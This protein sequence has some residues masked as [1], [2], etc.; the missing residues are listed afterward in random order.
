MAL[1]LTLPVVQRRGEIEDLLRRFRVLVLTGETGSGKTTQLPQ[2]VWG[3]REDGGATR[4]GSRGELPPP[5]PH[6]LGTSPAGGGGG[7]VHTQ[8]RRLAARAVA[9]RIAEEMG[10]RVGGLVGYKVRFEER[11]SRE[12]GITVMTDGMLLAEIAQDPELSAYSTVILDEAHERSLNVDILLGYLK[13]L[14]ERR[15]DLRVIVTSAT[16]EPRRFSDFFGGPAVA[17]VL[18]VS[19][20]TYGVEVRY[21]T[22]RW[23]EDEDPEVDPQAVVEAVDELT[24]PTVAAGDVLVFLP[25][26]REIR[27]CAEALR[28]A[29]VDAE[30]LPLFSKLSN[31]EQDRIFHWKA[32]GK[33]RVILSTN[34]AETSLTVPGIRHVVDTGL[35]RRNFYDAGRKVQTLPVVRVSRASA[36]Q[37]KGRCGRVAAGVCVRL[38]SEKGYQARPVFTEPEIRRT[39]LASVILQVSAMGLSLERLPLLDPPDA[40]AV[41]EGYE[42]LVELGA[43]TKGTRVGEPGSGYRITEVGRRLSRLPVDPRIG[44]MLV[45]AE[46]EGCVGEVVVLAAGLSIQDPRERPMERAG[47]ADEAHKV[48]RDESSDFLTLLNVYEQYQHAAEDRGSSALASWC[49]EHFINANRMREWEETARQLGD[50]MAPG[51]TKAPPPALLRSATSPAGGGGGERIH[52]ALLTGLLSNLACRTD[53]SGY[54]YKGVKGNVVSLFPGSVLFKKGPKWIM[55]AEV[56]QTTKLYA[57]TVAGVPAEWIEELAGHV[58]DRQLTDPHL[59]A[60]TGEPSAWERS[61]MNGIVVVPRRRVAIAGSDPE[62]ARGLFI[63][64]ALVLGKWKG[65]GGY[66]GRVRKVLESAASVQAKLRRRGVVKSEAELVAW[67]ERALPK[68]VVDPG[69]LVEWRA[70]TQ[71]A[72]AGVPGLGDVLNPEAARAASEEAYPS[73]LACEA[74]KPVPLAYVFEAG[75]DEDGVTATVDVGDLPAITAE[76]AAWLVPGMLP[77]VVAGL[78]KTIGK[79]ER[80]KIEAKGELG[81]VASGV[82][83]VLEFGKGAIAAA[84]AEAVGVLHGV[85]IEAG[86]FSPKALPAYLKLRV[87]V[88]DGEKEVG[89]GRDVAELQEKLEAKV[90]KARGARAK[91]RFEREGIVAW[92]FGTLPETIEEEGR[93]PALVDRGEACALTLVG[94]KEEAA[95][96]TVLGVRRLFAIACKEQIAHEL[97]ALAAW[98]ELVKH[99]G[100]FG[101]AAALRSDLTCLIAERAFLSGGAVPRTA[102]QFDERQQAGW[103]RLSI[104]V[105]EVADVVGRIL[106]PR[107]LVAKRLASGTNRHWAMSMADLREQAAYLMPPGFVLLV[108]WE[109]LKEFPRYS[110]AMRARLLGLR[111]DGSGAEKQLLEQYLPHWKKF[112]GWVAAA[113]SKERE[114]E[115]AGAALATKTKAALPQSRRAAPTVNLD[116]GAW[117]M[118]P[119]KLPAAV[120][121][122]RWALEELRL[123]MFAPELAGKNAPTV[124]GVAQMWK[125]TGG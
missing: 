84:V 46:A 123:A 94:S 20:R 52:R 44:R 105:R 103:G 109:R 27:R 97:D 51:E 60:E 110:A 11:V 86:A 124:A 83:E 96:A 95:A 26:E 68:S 93:F 87:V 72:N 67:F 85:T 19:G 65:A 69:T 35:E 70:S 78:F 76:R 82:A 4:P 107:F 71:D 32:G 99:Y 47:A 115:E 10:V 50:L 91:A 89:A 112:T 62:R 53:G 106:E 29:R 7:I 74:E 125:G 45:A 55:A 79:Q 8:P 92:D 102:E 14:L 111:E 12:T 30:V 25:G 88:M 39:S 64:D 42:T 90:A 31:A 113:M 38:Y 15:S 23:H 63:R 117:A 1:D 49:R 122:Y 75:S 98:P 118:Q 43:V 41:A 2:I 9:S 119:G 18:E 121:K 58:L 17:P 28:A 104:V 59:D 114:A 37:R 40:K 36:D 66:V 120:E 100:H 108:P 56:V 77:E 6:R 54:E 24:G 5:R 3:M 48:F 101:T 22:A 34:V 73:V 61:T 16:I 33:T 116:A 81:E 80:Q 13:G 21:R 57:R